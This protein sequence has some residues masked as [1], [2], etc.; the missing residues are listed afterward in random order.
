MNLKDISVV[1][2]FSLPTIVRQLKNILGDIKFNEIKNKNLNSAKNEK[3]D[4]LKKDKPDLIQESDYLEERF[5]M[6]Q[7]ELSGYTCKYL[8]IFML[9]IS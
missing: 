4:N 6:K 8:S 5:F 3:K 1:Y 7:P 2:N 9:E